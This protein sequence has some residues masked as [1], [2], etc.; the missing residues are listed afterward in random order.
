[1]S[2][3]TNVTWP[4]SI[5]SIN[6]TTCIGTCV[7][8]KKFWYINIFFFYWYTWL[9]M[10]SL[11]SDITTIT[12]CELDEFLAFSMGWNGKRFLLC[13]DV[14]YTC[15]KTCIFF[16][17]SSLT[18]C[19]LEASCA[20]PNTP[21]T[22]RC[23][24]RVFLPGNSWRIWGPCGLRLLDFTCCILSVCKA[25]SCQYNIDMIG[26]T[27]QLNTVWRCQMVGKWFFFFFF[28]FLA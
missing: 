28:D 21:L 25:V 15:F 22:Y 17:K 14:Y 27:C 18:S 8:T 9:N 5:I 11:Q 26:A 3:P 10:G 24:G 23:H 6:S 4:L 1:M 13:T 12:V 2:L 16:E 20:L 19:K 7:I